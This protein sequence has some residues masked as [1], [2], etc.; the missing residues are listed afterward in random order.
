MSVFLLKGHKHTH[1]HVHAE[2]ERG[3]RLPFA[4]SLPKWSCQLQLASLEPKSSL[5]MSQAP[6]PFFAALLGTLVGS[7]IGNG[8]AVA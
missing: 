5:W 2:K 6:G 7:W 1:T 8:A 3:R 4:G